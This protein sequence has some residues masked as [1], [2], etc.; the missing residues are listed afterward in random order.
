LQDISAEIQSSE[1]LIQSLSGTK[2]LPPLK[3]QRFG[4]ALS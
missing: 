3:K 4:V 1:L 2:P